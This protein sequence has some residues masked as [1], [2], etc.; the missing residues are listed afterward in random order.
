MCVQRK[1]EKMQDKFQIGVVTSA[2]GV[3][4]EVKVF[5]TTDEPRKFKKIGKVILDTG[6]EEKILD[7]Q[8]VKF[9]KNLVILKFV[10]IETMDEAEKLRQK[11]LWITR[12]QSG[13]LRKDEYYKADLMDLQVYDEDE[14]LLGMISDIFETGANDVYEMTDSS[15]K[16]ILLPAIKDCIKQID[17]ENRKM[18]IHVMDGL[19]DLNE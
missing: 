13:P 8:S 15:G 19:L 11:T 7:I 6:K 9:F 2:H 17:M 18:I 1:G 14:K 5:P 16:K 12:E 10:G 3:H 4:G